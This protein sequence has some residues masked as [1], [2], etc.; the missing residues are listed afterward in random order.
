MCGIGG[1]TRFGGRSTDGAPV[2]R[3][4]AAMTS[5]GPEMWLQS[6]AG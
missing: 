5:R 1:E 6:M 3:T 2:T 4:T